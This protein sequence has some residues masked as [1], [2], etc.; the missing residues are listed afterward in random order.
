MHRGPIVII[1]LDGLRRDAFDRPDQGAKLAPNLTK[2][3]ARADWRGHGIAAAGDG[4]GALVSAMTGLRPSQYLTHGGLALAP[5]A[6]AAPTTAPAALTL[7]EALDRLGYHGSGFAPVRAA[8]LGLARG[9]DEFADLGKD[10]PAAAQLARLGAGRTFIWVHLPEPHAPFVRRDWLLGRLDAVPEKLPRRLSGAQVEALLA[11]GGDSDPRVSRTLRALYDLN[12]AWGDERFGRLLAALDKSGQ[13]ARTLV[14][15][16]GVRGDNFAEGGAAGREGGLGRTAL[17]TPVA[18]DFP[19]DFDRRP[20]VSNGQ[21]FALARLFATLLESVGISPPPAV[22]P[23]LYRADPRPI[24][25][26]RLGVD[27]VDRFSLLAGEDQLLATID[28]TG[29]L[30]PRFELL[31][32]SNEP[33]PE[34]Q[35]LRARLQAQLMAAR[36][37]FS[38]E[39]PLLVPE[40]VASPR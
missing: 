18:M 36:A 40:R 38:P 37:S 2:F 9:F 27:G 13:R 14:V 3:F 7:A 29:A 5:A 1:T 26:E 4:D 12:L 10:R 20:A 22:A 19:D 15:V 39:T 34:D 28:P 32:W 8:R 35:H 17:E 23:S 6:S 21:R 24:L 31:R 25:S 33:R 11:A 30:A 16:G